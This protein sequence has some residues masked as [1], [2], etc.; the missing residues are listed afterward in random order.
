M[1]KYRIT[2]NTKILF[3]PGRIT[4]SKKSTR[5]FVMYAIDYNREGYDI[6]LLL[7][8]EK[9]KETIYTDL[10]RYLVIG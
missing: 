10:Q 7:A 9:Q 6:V 5:C 3:H 8:G 1:D 4:E 2:S